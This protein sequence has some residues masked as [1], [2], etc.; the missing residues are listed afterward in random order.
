MKKIIIFLILLSMFTIYSMCKS[1][2]IP[3]NDFLELKK[4]IM[5]TFKYYP[6]FKRIKLSK[7]CRNQ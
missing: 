2:N 6:I 1:K 7:S 5:K 4:F 3:K